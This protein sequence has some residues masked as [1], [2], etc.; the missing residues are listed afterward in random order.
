[1]FHTGGLGSLETED[2][3]VWAC[4]RSYPCLS[5]VAKTD[6]MC[7]KYHEKQEV[8]HAWVLMSEME[9]CEAP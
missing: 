6:A 8:W 3:D 4:F 2:Y 7:Y 9:T 1:M 5:K